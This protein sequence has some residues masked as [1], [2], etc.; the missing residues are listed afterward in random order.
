MDDTTY[1]KTLEELYNFSQLLS[2]HN[3]KHWLDWGVLLHAHRDKKIH[4]D[5]ENDIDLGL[6]KQDW[7]K[8]KQLIK[9]NNI[10]YS[11]NCYRH[12]LHDGRLVKPNQSLIALEQVL[13]YKRLMVELVSNQ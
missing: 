12:N 9:D 3:I 4:V 8:V 2:Q 6:L 10:E 13:S 5:S 7:D 1:K 11:D